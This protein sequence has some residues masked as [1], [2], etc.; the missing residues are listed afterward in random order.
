MCQIGGPP[1]GIV[2]ISCIRS[3]PGVPIERMALINEL[4]PSLR[5]TVTHA[6]LK[7]LNGPACLYLCGEEDD[8]YLVERAKAL[9]QLA[10]YTARIFGVRLF[11]YPRRAP[12]RDA[13]AQA[14]AE[15]AQ[16]IHHT[17]DDFVYSRQGWLREA[18][19][20][21]RAAVP[22]EIGMVTPPATVSS[23]MAALV[24]SSRENMLQ[25][26]DTDR[27][28]VRSQLRGSAVVSRVHLDI[29]LDFCPATPAEYSDSLNCYDW[30]SHTYAAVTS[31]PTLAPCSTSGSGRSDECV[32]R[33]HA[34]RLRAELISCG[35]TGVATYSLRLSVAN[36]T[37]A[38]AVS[39]PPPKRCL[40]GTP[41]REAGF[42]WN[43]SL[44]GNARG[45]SS[46]WQRSV[47]HHRMRLRGTGT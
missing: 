1:P 28:R 9:R 10:A 18:V 42:I 30:L 22:R 5:Q 8:S 41:T 7:I 37:D 19:Q 12:F 6:D 26:G 33:R 20:A 2:V 24:H 17:Y 43:H 27:F 40:V 39:L 16:F 38:R 46:N 45:A 13:A 29:F 44:G 34:S 11:F 21:L 3:A 15:G 36:G 25:S 23:G 47:A 32:V 31:V 14:Y 4:L 35:R